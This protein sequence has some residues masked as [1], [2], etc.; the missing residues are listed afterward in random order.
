MT[1][2]AKQAIHPSPNVLRNATLPNT[3]GGVGLPGAAVRVR[4][5]RRPYVAMA[6][7]V[8]AALA[9]VLLMWRP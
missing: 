6:S 7:G 9:F 3:L 1:Q 8:L 4:R 2:I 5:P